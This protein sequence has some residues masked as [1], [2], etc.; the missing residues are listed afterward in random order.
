MQSREIENSAYVDLNSRDTGRESTYQLHEDSSNQGSLVNKIFNNQRAACVIIIISFL[1]T[2]VA[3]SL[4]ALY[5]MDVWP[6]GSDASLSSAEATITDT[7]KSATNAS[8]TTQIRGK[9]ISYVGD[10]VPGGVEGLKNATLPTTDYTTIQ[11]HTELTTIAN[12]ITTAPGITL[13][14][15]QPGFT[16]FNQYTTYVD[17]A[18]KVQNYATSENI[19]DST[20]KATEFTSVEMVDK[21][22]NVLDYDK[23]N[24]SSTVANL[25]R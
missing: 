15:D 7:N 4:V 23:Y 19:I 22:V 5:A 3:V 2:A 21:T 12:D 17:D 13:G 6:M 11:E 1:V 9:W 25:R 14:T 18:V 10:L 24:E 8:N 20:I 16:D